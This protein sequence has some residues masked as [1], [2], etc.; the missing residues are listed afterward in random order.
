MFNYARSDTHFL[1][2][3]YDHMR[4]ELIEKSDVSQPEGDLIEVVMNDSKEEALQRYE[5]PRYDERTGSGPIGWFNLLCRTPA[6]FS[7]EQFA[8]FR[9]IHQWRDTLARQ[10]D[11][12]VHA[13]MPKHVLFNIAREM[14]LDMPSLLGCSH[15]MSKAFQK[16][17]I[18]LLE[19]IKQA[20]LAGATGPEMK[21]FISAAQSG[22]TD[23]VF[24]ASKAKQTTLASIE[25]GVAV[26][27]LD[28]PSQSDSIARA[29][30]SHFWGLTAFGDVTSSVSKIRSNDDMLQLALPMPQLTKEPFEDHKDIK[31][32]VASISH[33]DTGARAEHRYVKDRKPRED[34][35][36][37]VKQAG[38]S[39]KR[40]TSD[41]ENSSRLVS[42]DGDGIAPNRIATE[43]IAEQPGVVNAKPRKMKED[44]ELAKREHKHQTAMDSAQEEAPEELEPFDYASAPSVL[45]AR[46][47]I[48]SSTK[49]VN[50]YAKATD[51]PKGM[52]KT[53]K[54]IE[55]K[56]LT[57]IK[58]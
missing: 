30:E 20:R 11:E 23:H 43:V 7:K 14:P 32:V 16:S 37:V 3:I 58:H 17:K 45:H 50:P 10:E 9:A 5:R 33:A 35:V 46:H 38:G 19:V 21:N 39:R 28:P 29:Q 8:V 27:A 2:H 55:G 15:P 40:K 49:G 56:S 53:Q 57:F 18:Y 31:H 42:A 51:A 1:L 26:R 13:V 41:F 36:F 44:K 22:S 52:R 6:L 25:Q 24:K 12:S 34:D 4:N 54:D 48:N 47:N